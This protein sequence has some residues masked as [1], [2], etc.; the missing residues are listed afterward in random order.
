MPF[1]MSTIVWYNVLVQIN[2][3]SKILPSLKVSVETIKKEIKAV[4]N[5][6][7]EF[8]NEGLESVKPDARDIAEK[9]KMQLARG[10]SDEEQLDTYEGRE[11]T[12]SA[13]VDLFKREFFLPLIDT[14]L[15]TLKRRDF[16]TWKH[17]TS[18]MEFSSPLM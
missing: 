5:F 1:V 6:F 13:K 4:T 10:G 11:Q 8:R 7:E 16:H 17:F 14:A 18:C 2:K 15:V 3:V 9:L 12:Q